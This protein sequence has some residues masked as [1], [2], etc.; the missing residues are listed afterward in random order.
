MDPDKKPLPR[1]TPFKGLHALGVLQCRRH[2]DRLEAAGQFPKRVQISENRVAWPT[3]E[4]VAFVEAM[5]AART[6]EAGRLGSA[7]WLFG[8]GKKASVETLKRLPKHR[9]GLKGRQAAPV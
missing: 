5:I 7:P 8:R 1:L 4:V 3:N 6:T 9:A 2:I